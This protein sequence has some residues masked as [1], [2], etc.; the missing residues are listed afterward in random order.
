MTKNTQYVEW[1]K[2][3]GSLESD[4]ALI[5]QH[6][7]SRFELGSAQL[8]CTNPQATI[9][10]VE[11][12]WQ[13]LTRQVQKQREAK[14]SAKDILQITRTISRMQR[15]TFS[16]SSPDEDPDAKFY[17]LTEKELSSLPTHCFTLYSIADLPKLSTLKQLPADALVV[18][19]SRQKNLEGIEKKKALEARIKTEENAVISWLGSHKIKLEGLMHDI[20]KSNEALD[21]LLG[22]NN[23]QSEFLH[24]AKAYLQLIRLA[25]PLKFDSLQQ[26]RIQL[27][28]QLEHQVR[29]LSPA[30][31]SDHILDSQS[32]DSFL[33]RD[34][35]G[36]KLL[37]LESLK[38][39]I[40]AQYHQ[41]HRHLAA[42]LEQHAG[43]IRL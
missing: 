26:Q 11:K 9:K 7:Q 29:I 28:E 39:F 3:T 2:H 14:A 6:W 1:K 12:C 33:L 21:T 5:M 30:F 42:A 18:P 41:G 19:F 8:L 36:K 37:T 22:S 23:L 4:V 20:E 40:T 31:L 27:I 13:R 24:R 32:D 35:T 10:L 25:Q 16:S 15:V 34:I 43:F 17:V 38:A